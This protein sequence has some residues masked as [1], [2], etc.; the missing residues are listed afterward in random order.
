MYHVYP[1]LAMVRRAA[2]LHHV[3]SHYIT[4]LQRDGARRG[5]AGRHP[6]HPGQGSHVV[7][8][9]P[10]PV[11]PHTTPRPAAHARISG[12]STQL[13]SQTNG[14]TSH[15]ARL[16]THTNYLTPAGPHA[17]AGVFRDARTLM[18]RGGAGQ[19]RRGTRVPAITTLNIWPLRFNT[20]QHNTTQH[21]TT[22]NGKQYTGT[23]GQQYQD[24]ID[25]AATTMV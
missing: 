6:P 25:G 24:C 11:P 15:A 9:S 14:N 3:T 19:G 16:G 20:T 17:H 22:L 21:N 1:I 7:R 2:P 8:V 13:V 12:A 4:A 18:G 10:R 5:G 23:T